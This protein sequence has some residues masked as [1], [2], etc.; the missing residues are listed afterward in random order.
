MIAGAF[1]GASCREVPADATTAT[2]AIDSQPLLVLGEPTDD[3]SGFTRIVGLARLS[4]GTLVVADAGSHELRFFAATG[5]A[6]RRVGRAGDGPGE[7][8]DI[9][10]IGRTSADSLYVWDWGLRRVS[11]FGPDGS[12][13]RRIA[14]HASPDGGRTFAAAGVLP[15]GGLVLERRLSVGLPFPGPEAGIAAE[16]IAFGMADAEGRVRWVGAT[17][18][19]AEVFGMFATTGRGRRLMPVYRPFGPRSTWSLLG[20]TLLVSTARDTSLLLI[21]PSDGRISR[22]ALRRVRSA[23]APASRDAYRA[24]A[25]QAVHEFAGTR[26]VQA[27]AD[28]VAA[29]EADKVPFPTLLPTNDR[30]V[31]APAGAVWVQDAN[32]DGTEEYRTDGRVGSRVWTIVKP[33]DTTSLHLELPR[34]FRLLLI[35]PD[36]ILGVWSDLD[37]IESIRAYTVHLSGPQ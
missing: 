17:M 28:V 30:I 13:A 34:S 37:G 36:R 10:W 29:L 16:S 32:S 26:R 19:D 7:F 11:V 4:D 27:D 1:G 33:G 23:L 8:R 21:D 24:A 31:A 15:D 2:I 35:E 9:A 5:E 6:L 12:Y 22:L 25:T 14:V 3:S 20:D 18:P